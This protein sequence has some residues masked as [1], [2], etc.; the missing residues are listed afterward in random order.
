MI[1]PE[2]NRAKLKEIKARDKDQVKEIIKAKDRIR[3]AVKAV[4]V[5]KSAST[6]QT[7]KIKI[8]VKT[9]VKARAKIKARVKD[10]AV[11][12]AKATVVVKVTAGIKTEV[13][14]VGAGAKVEMIDIETENQTEGA[15]S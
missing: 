8:I 14:I 9:A 11:D 7:V 4:K 6:I 3:L 10:L 5:I 12:R 2:A 1:G 15:H 13:E